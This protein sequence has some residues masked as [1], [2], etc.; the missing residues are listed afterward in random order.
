MGALTALAAV[1]L[2]TLVILWTQL[3]G[4]DTTAGLGKTVDSPTNGPTKVGPTEKATKTTDPPPTGDKKTPPRTAGT[5]SQ[6]PRTTATRTTAPSTTAPRTTAP[7]T[8]A[9]TTT[10]PSTTA[11]TRTPPTKPS[12][13]KTPPTKTASTTTPPATTTQNAGAAPPGFDLA[14]DPLGFNVAVPE[15]W[16]RR[17]DGATRVDYVNPNN[18]GN[19]LRIDQIPQA[20]PDAYQAWVEYEENTLQHTFEDYQR[21]RLERVN[22]RG[23]PAA[24]L[25]WTYNDGTMRVLD[26]GFITDP[27]GFAILMS[28]PA[29][30]WETESRPVFDVAASTFTP[31][32][33]P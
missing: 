10:A 14:E 19:Y 15:G 13:T 8:T 12:P 11:F 4:S 32:F 21:I 9:P 23:W 28:G 20:G 5:K 2:V 30:T 25:E 17:L 26:R 24:D 31:T 33:T 27:R 7:R 1:A 29:S 22:F 6:P 3:A 16:Y 18:S